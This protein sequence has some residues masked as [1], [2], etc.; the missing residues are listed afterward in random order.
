MRPVTGKGA[1][2][3]SVPVRTD[4]PLH[5]IT[6]GNYWM[7][8][9]IE[10]LDGQGK[11]RLG[12]GMSAELITAMQNGALR[13]KEQLDLAATLTMSSNGNSVKIVNHTGHKL[14]SGYPEGRRMWL[15]IKWYDGN[16]VLVGEAGEYGEIGVTVDGVNVRSLVDL[17]GNG[18]RIY[19]VHMGMTQQWA[20]QLLAL[21]YAPG[22]ELG[23]DRITGQPVFTLGQLA[24]SPP[25]TQ[26]ETFHFV[27]NNTVVK[28][29]RIPPYGMSYDLARV[30]NALPVPA[31]QYGG[32]PGGNFDY[33]D[34]VPLNPPAAAQSAT[35]D[36]LY[37]PTSWEY[38]QFLALANKGSDPAQGGNAFLGEEG[39]NMLDAWLNTGMAEP[40]V[41]ASTTWGA[42]PG[43]CDATAPVLLAATAMDKKVSANWQEIPGD[44][45]IIGYR[46]FYDQAGK[47]Q[48]VVD[49]PCPPGEPGACSSYT[50]TGL[51]NGQQY[52]YKA[53]SYSVACESGFSNILCATPS[54]PGQPPGC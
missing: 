44:P 24:A 47:A 8:A 39:V 18:T 38:I 25:D 32:A 40:H 10:Y 21:G 51:S 2:K 30:R 31:S 48:L 33:F 13:A 17:D 22:L 16:G 50:D 28:D 12:G 29:N 46:L 20:A 41:M 15:N 7:P 54:P 3:Q 27:L 53:T 42:P 11:L 35:I 19:E 34:E 23:Y 1:N 52:C 5:D 4:L 49:L 43:E 26:H 6:G 9:A 36:L 45:D 37:Q 14:I